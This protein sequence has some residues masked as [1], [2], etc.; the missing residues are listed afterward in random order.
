M[1]EVVP[2]GNLPDA[3]WQ[4]RGEQ[5]RPECGRGAKAL[6]GH[7]HLQ[8][9]QLGTR[10]EEQRHHKSTTAT[11]P[12]YIIGDIC[13]SLHTKARESV[14]CQARPQPNSRANTK[15][16]PASAT[17]TGSGDLHPPQ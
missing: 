3:W 2:S 1:A 7:C 9:R 8:G 15:V 10:M 4:G 13:Y 5:G 11:P 17:G 12:H 6:A 14:A 16:L